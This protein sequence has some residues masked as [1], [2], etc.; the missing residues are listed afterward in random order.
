[1]LRIQISDIISGREINLSLQSVYALRE[2]GILLKLLDSARVGLGGGQSSSNSSGLLFSQLHGQL[3]ALRDNL[4]AK[5]GLGLLIV[6]SQDSGNIL[7]DHTNLRKLLRGAAADF[8][9]AKLYEIQSD[10]FLS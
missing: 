3:S 2:M 9:N 1:M 5:L 7:S 4:L 8:R 6:H 10:K